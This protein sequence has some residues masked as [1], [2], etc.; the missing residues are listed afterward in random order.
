MGTLR[1][2][3]PTQGRNTAVYMALLPKGE[4][5]APVVQTL[6]AGGFTGSVTITAA[7]S[8]ESYVAVVAGTAHTVVAGTTDTKKT[9]AKAL[10]ASINAGTTGAKALNLRL[11]GSDY[12][13]D[14][15]RATTFTL[16][17]TGTTTVGSFAV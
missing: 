10:V 8:T 17:N 7:T 11:S 9:I 4:R 5:T 12:R 3:T 13:F 1:K 14:V 2:H 15:Y 6:V 16:A